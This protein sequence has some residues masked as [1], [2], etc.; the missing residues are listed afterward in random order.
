MNRRLLREHIFKLLFRVEFNSE[1]EMN[2]QKELFFEDIETEF[3]VQDEEFIKGKY[4]EINAHLE[5]IDQIIKDNAK[6]WTIDRIGKVE[7][8]IIRLA[9][10]EIRFDDEVPAQV[11]I[12]EAV[13]LAKKFGP[14]KSAGFVNAV[15]A[16][17]V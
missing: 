2:E 4:D 6:G 14:D 8:T 12:N 17:L 16:K 10:F 11:A 13:E 9:I 15:L 5:E 1:E 7:L 3:D